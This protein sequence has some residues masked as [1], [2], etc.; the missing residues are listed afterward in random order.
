MDAP[1]CLHWNEHYS[2]NVIFRIRP[3]HGGTPDP[4]TGA[5]P[6][7]PCWEDDSNYG[8]CSGFPYGSICPVYGYSLTSTTLTLA[9]KTED[10]PAQ[11]YF[12]IREFTTHKVLAGG[13]VNLSAL[14]LWDGQQPT[15]ENPLGNLQTVSIELTPTE[16][17]TEDSHPD[18]H[19]YNLKGRFF[20][21]ETMTTSIGTSSG[22]AKLVYIIKYTD[23][24]WAWMMPYGKLWGIPGGETPPLEPPSLDTL[25]ALFPNPP[26][27]E[28]R[29][30]LNDY[31]DYTPTH[32]S[33]KVANNPAYLPEDGVDN[34]VNKLGS[35]TGT[36]G[37]SWEGPVSQPGVTCYYKFGVR[38]AHPDGDYWFWGNAEQFTIPSPLA[39]ETDPAT[40]I[41]ET[42]ADLNMTIISADS[43]VNAEFQWGLTTDYGSILSCGKLGE[44]EHSKTLPNLSPSTTYHFRARIYDD[45]N[46]VAVGADEEFTTLAPGGGGGDEPGEEQ[47]PPAVEMVSASKLDFHT[48]K[49]TGEIVKTCENCQT[50]GFE[51]SWLYEYCRS[52]EPDWSIPMGFGEPPMVW[53]AQTFTPGESHAVDRIGLLCGRD[54]TPG[55]ITVSIKNVD[56]NG[57]PSGNDLGTG[58]LNG[59][60]VSDVWPEWYFVDISPVAVSAD[61]KY[62]LVLHAPNAGGDNNFYWMLKLDAYAGGNLEYIGSGET[63]W[64][65]VPEFDA[66]FQ[67]WPKYGLEWVESGS[68]G[69][70]EFSHNIGGLMGGI[71]YYCRCKAENSY[72]WSYSDD[73]E[74]TLATAQSFSGAVSIAGAIKR[75]I[76]RTISGGITPAGTLHKK[77]YKSVGGTIAISGALTHSKHLK[78]KVGCNSGGVK[79]LHFLH[80]DL[81]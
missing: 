23:G 20:T 67:V 25:S 50:R 54:G 81:G 42:S 47:M 72:G 18:Y 21:D 78:R 32:F 29:G 48:V 52:G 55:N 1:I 43:P 80:K 31:G 37:Y 27:V 24:G 41:G 13:W 58:T 44:G 64:T 38:V 3:T 40:D 73:L 16:N 6:D 56:E 8:H 19:G 26:D 49:L 28:L 65:S 15:E 69:A 60:N 2:S 10:C 33:F 71:P 61:V 53:V 30:V 63:D 74:F 36:G 5:G 79:L 76:A 14:P 77:L 59:N 12:A 70:G 17:L 35:I 57:H 62:A 75:L 22:T 9:R 51:L 7:W 46:N 11:G 34:T 68:F 39:V 45:A 66:F 4:W